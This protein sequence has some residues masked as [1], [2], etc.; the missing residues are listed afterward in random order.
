MNKIKFE[1]VLSYYDKYAAVQ[2]NGKWGYIDQ[3]GEL[4]VQPIYDSVEKANYWPDMYIAVSLNGKY[5]VLNKSFEEIIHPQYDE[6]GEFLY[7]VAAVRNGDKWGVVDT[8]GD[9]VV[10]I[11]YAR[12]QPAPGGNAFVAVK[13][14][15]GSLLWGMMDKKG[16]LVIPTT[17]CAIQQ[18][19]NSLIWSKRIGGKHVLYKQNGE[20]VISGWEQWWANDHWATI[21]LEKN[22]ITTQI[23]VICKDDVEENLI[24]NIKGKFVC[25]SL[26]PNGWLWVET[27]E[28]HITIYN[29]SGE[30][31]C[32]FNDLTIVGTS[33]Y[34]LT[35]TFTSEENYSIVVCKNSLGYTLFF[36][37]YGEELYC[38]EK[39]FNGDCLNLASCNHVFLQGKSSAIVVSLKHKKSVRVRNVKNVLIFSEDSIGYVGSKGFLYFWAN[40]AKYFEGE[41]WDVTY[42]NKFIV[43]KIGQSNLNTLLTTSG[44]VL[45]ENIE[46]KITIHQ[47]NCVVDYADH[48]DIYDSNGNCCTV[49]GY[50]SYE[51]NT[52]LGGEIVPLKGTDDTISFFSPSGELLYNLPQEIDEI[53][54]LRSKTIPVRNKFNKRWGLMNLKGELVI[55]CNQTPDESREIYDACILRWHC[56]NDAIFPVFDFYTQESDENDYRSG[57]V[58]KFTQGGRVGVRERKN[59]L[60]PPIFDEFSDLSSTKDVFTLKLDNKWYQLTRDKSLVNMAIAETE[61]MT[62]LEMYY[63]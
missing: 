53:G 46:D 12:T 27:I 3:Q 62:I 32:E 33:R 9:L 30:V 15:K 49:A 23:C 51:K 29:S 11:T 2:L 47:E 56:W 19:H 14:D 54:V 63:Y 5:G 60:I 37:E 55:E 40:D 7:G 39:P 8:K 57:A 34:E 26:S 28:K 1:K 22:N 36:N 58:M 43:A 13:L 16:N 6:I 31:A 24:L 48:C 20:V 38:L 42:S 25:Y 44:K 21:A 59:I 61:F 50:R 18:F 4:V 52:A 41:E 10:P 45:L 35:G 17:N